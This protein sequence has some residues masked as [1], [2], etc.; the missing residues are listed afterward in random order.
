[1]RNFSIILS[2]LTV[3]IVGYSQE[4]F[5][6]ELV[7]N[8]N[9]GEPGNDVW[10]YVDSTGTEYA[11][12]GTRNFTKIWSLEDPSNPIERASIPGPA[13]LWRDIKHFQDHLYVTSDQGDQGLLII[14]MSGAPETITSEYWKPSL[15]VGGIA[16]PLGKC[17]NLYIDTLTGYCFLSGCDIGNEGVL[18]LDLNQDK[19]NPVHVGTVDKQYSHDSYVLN[20]ILY[21]SDILAGVL[22][23][24]DVSDVT[25]PVF[26]GEQSTSRNFCHN[27]WTSHDG[28]YAFTTDERANAWLDAYDISDPNDIKFLDRY[29]PL[30]TEDQGLIPHNTHYLDGFLITSWYTDGIVVLDANSPDNLIKVASYDTE[31]VFTNGFEG[32]WGAYPF[33]PSGLVLGGDINHGLFIFQPKDFD[34]NLGYQ[35]AS[36]LE[37]EVTDAN[38]G[39]AIPN[40]KIELISDQM[41]EAQTGIMGTYKTGLAKAGDYMVRFTHPN[42]SPIELPVTLESGEVTILNAQLG[43]AIMSGAVVIKENGEGA[44]GA[45]VV[46]ENVEEGTSQTVTADDD[47]QWQLL[48]GTDITYKIH[49]GLWGYLNTSMDFEFTQ[50]ASIELELEEGYQDDFF[51]DLGWSSTGS[52][53]TGRWEI[54]DATRITGLG[55]VSQTDE[56]IPSDIGSN[57]YVT[58]ASGSGAGENDIDDGNVVLTS[59]AM[60]MGSYDAMDISFYLWFS[61]GGGSGAPND[62]VKVSVTNGSETIQLLDYNTVSEQWSGIFEFTVT[63]ADIAFTDDMR[64][65]F[66]AEDDD[67]GHVV[68]VGVDAF[69]A[70]GYTMPVNVNELEID[71]IG[72]VVFPNPAREYFN[73][74]MNTLW[75]GEKKMII[76]DNSGK[77]VMTKA[78]TK[79][80]SKYNVHSLASGIYTIQVV[81]EHKQSETL[82]VIKQ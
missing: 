16:Q 11:I 63:A 58:G 48:T 27:T 69:N 4:N 1:M 38:T 82:R 57:Y 61:N 29:R 18:I 26:L 15:T 44:S 7:A 25:S 22:S 75:D 60:L 40:A 64:I 53:P 65:I 52:S 39:A 23:I 49:A 20:D 14:D 73:V 9:F 71:N 32:A 81:G 21:S 50:G 62:Q 46:I 66:D 36:Y 76:T 54:G 34:G 59:P 30:E 70:V 24:Y 28:K 72:L 12:M 74:N 8:V 3:A 42:Y 33:L 47:G 51:A 6:M 43:N 68:E 5:N 80:E 78:I 31:L 2:F 77:V 10:G 67:P 41:N 56:D 79:E 45:K 17:H 35:R 55:F 19:T 37:G 13:G